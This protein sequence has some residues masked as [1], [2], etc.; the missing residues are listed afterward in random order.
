MH[1]KTLKTQENITENDKIKKKVYPKE[2]FFF[3][4][5]VAPN[6]SL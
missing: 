2:D 5:A 4:I 1:K 6:S 3:F